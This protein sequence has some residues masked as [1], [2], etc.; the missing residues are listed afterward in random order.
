MMLKNCLPIIVSF[1]VKSLALL[2]LNVS[3]F[4]LPGRLAKTSHL[5]AFLVDCWAFV[6]HNLLS[7]FMSILPS[8]ISKR[9]I[10]R[11]MSGS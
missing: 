5:Q 7:S 2:V 10:L 6:D 3:G 11:D 8:G 1:S 4:L 9:I